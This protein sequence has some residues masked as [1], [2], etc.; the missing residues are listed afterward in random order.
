MGR[1]SKRRETS[2]ESES[3]NDY[4]RY[5]RKS[6]SS[7]RKSKKRSSSQDNVSC[8]PPSR[9]GDNDS[10]EIVQKQNT[11]IREL[12]GMLSDFLKRNKTADNSSHSLII[13]AD[14]IPEFSPSLSYASAKKMARQN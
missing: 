12:E 11:R 2:S 5:R 9:N 7:R 1:K 14:C 6:G 4:G 13:R 8:T 3:D 10:C